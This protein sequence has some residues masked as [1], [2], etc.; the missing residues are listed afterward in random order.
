MANQNLNIGPKALLAGLLI[1]IGNISVM[2][3]TNEVFGAVLFALSLLAI[4]YLQLPLFVGRINKAYG[5]ESYPEYFV[6]LGFNF[7][8][9]AITTIGFVFMDKGMYLE[10]FRKASIEKYDRSWLALF[11]S[12]FMCSVLIH[13]AIAA[14]R[15]IITILC[16]VVFFLCNFE[17][18]VSS[19]GYLLGAFMP[20]GGVALFKWISIIAGNIVG[21]NVTGFLLYGADPGSLF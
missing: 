4:L 3:S 15:D 18:C 11:I 10:V 14:K 9:V 21:A 8:G 20:S 17:H 19:A 1:G 2:M 13:I 16:A 7:L 12:G 6:I 5:R